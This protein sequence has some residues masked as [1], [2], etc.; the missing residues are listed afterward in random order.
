MEGSFCWRFSRWACCRMVKDVFAGTCGGVAVTMIGHPV[1]TLKVLLQTQP[2]DKPVYRC[3]RANSF[4]ESVLAR[5]GWEL[6]GEGKREEGRWHSKGFPIGERSGLFDA[7]KKTV[8]AEGMHGLYRGVVSPLMGQMFFRAGLFFSYARAKEIVGANPSDRLSYF[9]AGALAWSVSSFFECPIDFYKSQMQ[10]QLVRM[11]RDPNYVP[12]YRS[13]FH[14][15]AES[16]RHNGVR[17]PYQ[18]L[19]ATLCRNVPAGSLYFGVFE[20]LKSKFGERNGTGHPTNGQI[21]LSGAMGGMLYWTTIY[22]VD[23][24]KSAMQTDELLRSDRKYRTFAQT[25]SLLFREGGGLGRFYKGITPCLVRASP[26]NAIMLF[27]VDKVKH[28]LG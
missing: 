22:P 4:A 15:M 7:A 8:K 2:S 24:I 9:K 3:A 25:A 11:R 26:A 13:I 21:I 1:D 27:T 16:V 14:C 20:Y 18:G 5:R 17:G 19:S 23:V 10:T 12:Q 6:R 28:W